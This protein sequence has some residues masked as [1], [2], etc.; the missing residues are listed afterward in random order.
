M[1]FLQNVTDFSLFQENYEGIF[2]FYR[3][4]AFIWHK[5]IS[6]SIIFSQY[7]ERIQIFNEDVKVNDNFTLNGSKVQKRSLK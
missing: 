6:S 1:L 2:E 7:H 3:K 4:R 5:N